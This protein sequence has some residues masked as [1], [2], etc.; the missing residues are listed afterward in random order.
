[1]FLNTFYGLIK[2]MKSNNKN[3]VLSIS[4]LVFI[5]G[6]A[7][8]YKKFF[9]KNEFIKQPLNISV[10][11][12]KTETLNLK[13][14]FTGKVVTKHSVVLTPEITGKIIYMKPDGSFVKKGETIIKLDAQE[15]QAK[16]KAHQGQ[17]QKHKK[18]LENLKELEKQGYASK[19][20]VEK[21]QQELNSA[22]GQFEEA[23]AYL[24][25]HTIK[26]SFD[27]VLGLHTQSMGATVNMHTKLITLT[28]FEEL[29]IEFSIPSSSLAIIGGI[30]K[31]KN[32]KIL[33]F[34]ENDLIPVSA[35]FAAIEGVID[36]ET[37]SILVRIDIDKGQKNIAPGQIAKVVINYGT[38]ENTLTVSEN[39]LVIEHGR[40]YVYKVEEN[41]AVQYTIKTGISDFDRIE[42]IE[43]VKQDDLIINSG[44]HRLSDG[45]SVNIVEEVE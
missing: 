3:I 33:V 16:C 2:F 23:Q 42:I 44:Q 36:A 32:S 13:Q 24:E 10:E 29:Q 6:I 20:H 1:M 14:E 8:V 35:K 25:K 4:G 34:I 9:K 39:A 5:F 38:K 40:E 37:N 11:K 7:L 41:L 17:V 12:V 15:A 18:E 30:E 45:Q 43:G 31:L 22:I 27:G 28:N 19:D 21:Q 26:A